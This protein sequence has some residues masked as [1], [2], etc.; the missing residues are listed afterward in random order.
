M[1]KYLITMP[2]PPYISIELT[3]GLGKQLFQ[4][5]ALLRLQKDRT[6]IFNN[7]LPVFLQDQFYALPEHDYRQISF[8]HFVYDTDI[9]PATHSNHHLMLKG[10]FASFH[11]ITEDIRKKM[12]NLVY[13]N[14]DLMY[15]AYDKYNQIKRYFGENTEDTDMISMHI[16]RNESQDKHSIYLDYY[17]MALHTANKKYVV[18]FSD[19]IEWCRKNIA[20]NLYNYENIYFVD[21]HSTPELDFILMSMFQHHIIANSAFSLWA[22][23]ISAYDNERQIIIAPDDWYIR[24]TYNSIYHR[25]I[26]QII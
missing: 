17:K 13:S 7:D 10:T 1:N 2:Q 26:T 12:I 24:K 21:T 15:T 25:K 5:A 20:R 18:V 22:S 6:I 9:N 14:E 11:N 8:T 16:K 3:E 19:D 23:F 4:I